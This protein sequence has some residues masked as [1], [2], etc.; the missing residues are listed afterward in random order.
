MPP[1]E[2]GSVL[3]EFSA[4]DQNGRTIASASLRGGPLVIFF[5]AED[6]TPSCTQECRDF[7]D[8]APQ[9]AR[10]KARIIGVS[11]QDAASHARFDAKNKLGYTLLVDKPAPD[12]VPPLAGLFGIW[13]E[14]SMYGRTYMGVVRTT[15]VFDA[16]GKLTAR[17]DKV[18][19][20][21]HARAVLD[22]L[23]SG[24]GGSAEVKPKRAA[25][26]VKPKARPAAKPA[27]K[28]ATAARGAKKRTTR[29]KPKA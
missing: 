4:S 12:G 5:Y 21:E 3:P 15:F 10:L 27:K 22:A 9:F 11:A 23:A 13:A 1:I 19:V 25:S 26:A 17:F 24:T 8:L 16:E 6:N 7:R 18:R 2:I 14:K 28:K 29:S 20:K